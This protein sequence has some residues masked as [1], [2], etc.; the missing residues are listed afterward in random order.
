MKKQAILYLVLIYSIIAYPQQ[1][2]KVYILSEGGFSPGSSK[3]SLLDVQSGNFTQSIFSPG[4]LGL[5]PDGLLYENGNVYVTE[6]GSYGSSGKIYK[7]DTLGQV[8]SSKVVGTNPYSLAIGS[9]KIYLTNGTASNVTVLNVSDFSFV[10]N[11]S[12]GVFPQEIISFNNKIFVANTSLWGGSL[13]STISVIDTQT[14]SVIA[15]IIVKKDPSSFAISADSFLLVGCP[16]EA[17][18]GII[19]KI[20]PLTYSIVDSFLIPVYGFDKD[21]AVDKNS[22]NIYF[23]GYTNDI[24]KY[25][26]ITR[27][28]SVVFS[29]IYPNNYYY[30]YNYDYTNKKHYMLDAKN[31]TVNG[32]LVIIDSSNTVMNN[33]QTG[34]A[35]RRVVLKYNNYPSAVK[36]NNMINNFILNQNYPNPFNPETKICWQ[37]PIE[38]WNTLIV[39]DLLGREIARL[40]DEYKPAGNY[41]TIFNMSNFGSGI[42]IYQL[43]FND[44]KTIRKFSN[45]MTLLK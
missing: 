31:F 11:I 45:K 15:K 13:D 39:Y 36:Q 4:N 33:F 30:G 17:N 14:D 29:S 24:I 27:N 35:P 2:S 3:L 26:T 16:G 37:T 12:V 5:Y 28:S 18:K 19:Y 40:L 42:Y 8:I 32:N 20:N 23:I 44:G 38:G 21:I 22:S 43:T 7:L 34:I 25:N 6:Q 41:S 9:G 1:L 10:K